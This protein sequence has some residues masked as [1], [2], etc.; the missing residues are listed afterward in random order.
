MRKTNIRLVLASIALGAVGAA[1]LSACGPEEEA[2]PATNGAYEA[3]PTT[4]Q[5][6]STAWL[7]D[8][9]AETTEAAAPAD[10][11]STDGEWI[12]PSEIAPGQ[13]KAVQDGTIS[14]YVA[15]CAD[16][17]C[18]IDMDGSDATGL[19]DNYTVDGQAYVTVPQGAMKVELSRAHLVPI[20]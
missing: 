16:L 8:I 5:A 12:V 3:A 6:P 2:K 18:E 4:T 9:L 13:Y 10:P 19:I 11:Y 14:G 17:E 15:V 7:D 1:S 20:N